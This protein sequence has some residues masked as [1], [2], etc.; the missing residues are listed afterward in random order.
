MAT[1]S[2]H[3]LREENLTWR[4]IDG[5]IVAVDIAASAYLSSNAAGAILWAMLAAGATREALAARL[6]ATYGID[7]ARAEAD[8]EA[9]LGSLDARG[10]LAS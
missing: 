1:G 4:E 6:V 8:V 7:R 5:E 3:Q 9:F 2:R 10:L